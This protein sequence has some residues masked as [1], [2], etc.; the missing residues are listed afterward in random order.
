LIES[1]IR[2]YGLEGSPTEKALKWI[3]REVLARYTFDPQQRSIVEG[4]IETHIDPQTKTLV[5]ARLEELS[6][7][8]GE[9]NARNYAAF[10]QQ[11]GLYTEREGYY[12]LNIQEEE[13]LEVVEERT[14]G[15]VEAGKEAVEPVR[16]EGRLRDMYNQM[17]ELAKKVREY[18]PRIVVDKAALAKEFRRLGNELQAVLNYLVENDQREGVF[19]GLERA[20]YFMRNILDESAR[21]TLPQLKKTFARIDRKRE[22]VQFQYFPTNQKEARVI[23]VDLR[24]GEVRSR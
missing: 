20:G 15:E 18:T 24:S 13:P 12:A 7:T 16:Y 19:K 14:V 8:V 10:F 21:P 4:M 1:L 17:S 23:T 2:R 11:I 9:E 6:K 3:E 5:P 22:R